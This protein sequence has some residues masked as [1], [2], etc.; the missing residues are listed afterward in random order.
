MAI[1]LRIT[2]CPSE[3]LLTRWVHLASSLGLHHGVWLVLKRPSGR[4]GARRERALL[5]ACA[6]A[7]AARPASSPERRLLVRTAA[8]GGAASQ[9]AKWVAWMRW[10]RVPLG[11]VCTPAPDCALRLAAHSS[12]VLRT[13]DKGLIRRKGARARRQRALVVET[14]DIAATHPQLLLVG[15]V[16]QMSWS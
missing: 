12:T 4:E 1:C 6:P 2:S 9:L 15:L 10:V 16:V 3:Q 13:T 14:C 5:C 7:W 8:K 11:S